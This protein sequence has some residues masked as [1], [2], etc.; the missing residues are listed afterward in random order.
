M[1]K[2]EKEKDK[3]AGYEIVLLDELVPKDHVLQKVEAT[4]YFD[5]VKICC[6]DSGTSEEKAGHSSDQLV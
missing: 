2:Q 3:L 5:K 1:R 4:L 6:T